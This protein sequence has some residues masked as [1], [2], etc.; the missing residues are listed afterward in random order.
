MNACPSNGSYPSLL[1][2]LHCRYITEIH[3]LALAG[4]NSQVIAVRTQAAAYCTSPHIVY[5]GGTMC[6][7]LKNVEDYMFNRYRLLLDDYEKYHQS[8]ML[9]FGQLPR[10]IEDPEMQQMWSQPLLNYT[11]WV[12]ATIAFT[13]CYNACHDILLTQPASTHVGFPAGCSFSGLP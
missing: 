9:G 6:T 10:R 2:H 12:K 1:G 5:S 8:V 4:D 7:P 13:V 11:V 3:Q